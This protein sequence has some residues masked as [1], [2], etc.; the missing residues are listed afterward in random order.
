[1]RLRAALNCAKKICN[2]GIPCKGR[3][4]SGEKAVCEHFFFSFVDQFEVVYSI[5]HCTRV[6]NPTGK[7]K[8]DYTAW[9]FSL[10]LK[11]AM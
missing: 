10:L 8:S 6:F 7:K 2:S 5:V 9:V 11:I 4:V 3:R 1:M